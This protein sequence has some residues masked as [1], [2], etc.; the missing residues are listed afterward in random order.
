MKKI[1]SIL[2]ALMMV[3]STGAVAFA[4]DGT[5]VEK[6]KPAKAHITATA[7][8]ANAKVKPDLKELDALKTQ[9]L[10]NKTTIAAIKADIKV[11]HIAVMAKIKELKNSDT[12]ITEEQIATIKTLKQDIKMGRGTYEANHKGVLLEERAMLKNAHANKDLE[13]IKTGMENIIKEQKSK[14][15]DL[16]AILDNLNAVLEALKDIK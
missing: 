15:N 13:A 8:Q 1:L 4:T 6:D 12:P 11:A 10:A 7:T 2:I 9:I 16:N 14:I 5:T 3:F